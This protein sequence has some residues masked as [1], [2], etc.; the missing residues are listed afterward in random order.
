MRKAPTLING[1]SI[2]VHLSD[3]FAAD[4]AELNK[5]VIAKAPMLRI[6]VEV[7]QG[8]QASKIDPNWWKT[9]S[10]DEFVEFLVHQE[11][12]AT[13]PP[14]LVDARQS[15]D[16]RGYRHRYPYDRVQSLRDLEKYNKWPGRQPELI[17]DVCRILAIPGQGSV[18]LCS[19]GFAVGS[20]HVPGVIGMVNMEDLELNASR[21]QPIGLDRDQVRIGWLQALHPHIVSSL[22]ELLNEGDVTD[23]LEFLNSVA[24]VYGRNLLLETN[25]PWLTIKE[26]TGDARQISVATLRSRLKGVREVLVSYNVSLWSTARRARECFPGAERDALV[27]PI[28]S[29]GQPEPGSYL[30]RDEEIWAPLEEHFGKEVYSGRLEK[31]NLLLATIDA[32]SSEWGVPE[33]TFLN[34]KW[35]RKNKSLFGHFSRRQT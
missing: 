32:I 9:V 33:E 7:V 11:L 23:R 4:L 25:L 3:Q 19:K 35:V 16:W 31:A 26:P 24:S 27:V 6:P 20:L 15:P 14:R 2:E 18:L 22:N 12:A 28:S 8:G 17:D 1:T 21:S 10:Q 13:T 30:D 34:A 29:L 5:I